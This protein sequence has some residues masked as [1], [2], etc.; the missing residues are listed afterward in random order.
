MAR[1]LV[2]PPDVPAD[3]VAALREAFAATMKDPAFLAEA[4][5]T[6]LEINPVTGPQIEAILASIFSASPDVVE[7]LRDL[8]ARAGGR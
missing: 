7:R 6:G 1:P 8:L 2:L 4:K 3:R 5:K